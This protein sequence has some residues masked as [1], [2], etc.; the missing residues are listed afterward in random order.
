M[1]EAGAYQ[2]PE[3]VRGSSILEAERSENSTRVQY[4]VNK[5]PGD[6]RRQRILKEVFLL[7]TWYYLLEALILLKIVKCCALK[8]WM[9]LQPHSLSQNDIQ[10]E[11][12]DQEAFLIDCVGEQRERI[13]LPYQQPDGN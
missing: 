3:N 1:L 10:N 7:F 11:Q 4:K 2:R 9:G 6:M 8:E 5:M 13:D 12:V